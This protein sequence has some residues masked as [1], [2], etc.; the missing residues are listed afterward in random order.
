[1]RVAIDIEALP[2][3]A[4]YG[5]VGFRVPELDELFVDSEGEEIV[6]CRQKA[7]NTP[8]LI[9]RKIQK[10]RAATVL[11]ITKDLMCRHRNNT[12][13][14]WSTSDEPLIARLCGWQNRRGHNWAVRLPG[15]IVE[16]VEFCEVLDE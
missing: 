6:L 8:R 16:W 12:N 10:W 4:G 2:C 14:S 5:P 3:L 15:G 7:V 11:D 1:M 9:V 13:V